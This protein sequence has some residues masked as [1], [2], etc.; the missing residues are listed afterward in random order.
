MVSLTR[1]EAEKREN[2][3]KIEFIETNLNV[4]IH[5]PKRLFK[6]DLSEKHE[7]GKSLYKELDSRFE[8][9]KNLKEEEYYQY[10]QQ[11]SD[12]IIDVLGLDKDTVSTGTLVA[13]DIDIN[14]ET[15]WIGQ[16]DELGIEDNDFIE[17]VFVDEELP[18]IFVIKKGKLNG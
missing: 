15:A 17:P 4:E 10:L 6:V 2:V 11:A 13:Y 3:Q 16:Y 14:N 12:I 9:F 8:E 5:S 18:P 7:S 1:N